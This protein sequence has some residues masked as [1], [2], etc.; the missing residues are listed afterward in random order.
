MVVNCLRIPRL[1]E[2]VVI[3][4]GDVQGRLINHDASNY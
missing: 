4:H 3:A 2:D 1:F